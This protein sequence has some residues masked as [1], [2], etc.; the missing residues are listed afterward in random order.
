M[1]RVAFEGM[2]QMI[3]SARARAP[4]FA[5][6]SFVPLIALTTAASSLS[7]RRK[8]NPALV[9]KPEAFRILAAVDRNK[10]A[11]AAVGVMYARLTVDVESFLVHVLPSRQQEGT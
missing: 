4:F 3:L 10:L 6:G 9:A 5:P 11:I 1:Q 8:L 7:G 2:P